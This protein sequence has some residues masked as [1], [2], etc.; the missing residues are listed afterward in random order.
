MRTLFSLFMLSAILATQCLFAQADRKDKAIF[1]E[2]KNEFFEKI[3]KESEKFSKK[4]EAPKK[5]LR[6]DFSSIALPTSIEQF[7]KQ[8]HTPPLSQGNSGMCWCFSTTSYFESEIYRLTKRQIKLSELYTVYWEYVEKTK[9]FIRERGNSEFAEGSESNAVTRI[10]KE[11]GIVPAE[12]YSGLL[13][14]QVYH[15]HSTMFNEM[16]T[17]LNSLKTS[18][19]WNEDEAIATIKSI[20]NHYLGEPPAA[21]TVNGKRMTPKEYRDNVVQLKLDDYYEFMSFVE[22]PYYQKA[23][24]EVPDNWWHSKEYYNVPLDDFMAVLKKAVRKGQTV[25]IGGDVSEAG[26]VT[27]AGAAMVPTFDIPSAFI[28][29]NARQFRFSN[30]TSGDDHGIHIVGYLEKDGKDW[31]L[32]KDSGSGSR[33]NSHPGYLFYHEDY[34]KLKMLGFTVHKDIIEDLLKKFK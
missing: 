12:A 9:R 8:W 2:T 13:P 21:V 16:N 14:G 27:T 18:K 23:E 15:D 19:G 26:Y 3:K 17:Y 34:V 29:E 32:I 33:N 11:Y 6:M 24:Y 10:W 1:V 31:Y 22:K 4:E 20:L 5:E 7:T 25:C 30:R 28:D